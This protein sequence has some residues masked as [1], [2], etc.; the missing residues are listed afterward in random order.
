[1]QRTFYA[2]V[3]PVGFA[4]IGYFVLVALA[5]LVPA[6]YLYILEKAKLLQIAVQS[7]GVYA[8]YLADVKGGKLLA[9]GFIQELL[10]P[11]IKTPRG[12][13]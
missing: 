1:M 2:F 7:S 9:L 10:Q 4:D 6:R 11:V 3:Q 12:G 13:A 8:F 5:V